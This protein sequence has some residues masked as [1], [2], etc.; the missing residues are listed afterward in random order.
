MNKVILCGNLCRDIDLKYSESGACWANSAIAINEK[1]KGE[2][3]T[4]FINITLFENLAKVANQYLN[5]GDKIL[6]TGKIN[7]RRYTDDKGVTR[8]DF[9][10]IVDDLE[11]INT[12][13]KPNL[14]NKQPNSTQDNKYISDD[15]E[16]PF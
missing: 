9:K 10:V 15:N 13:N 11:F 14:A 7:S 8:T 16:I 4:E 5:S 12:K 6:I 3:K 2:T 1:S